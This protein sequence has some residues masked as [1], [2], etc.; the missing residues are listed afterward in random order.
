M[1]LALYHNHD[2]DDDSIKW[3]V[4]C[5]V[6]HDDTHFLVPYRFTRHLKADSMLYQESENFFEVN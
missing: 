1:L 5:N 6:V 4:I 3:I 2:D